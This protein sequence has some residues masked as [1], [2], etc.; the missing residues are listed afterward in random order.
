MPCCHSF[1]DL[2]FSPGYCQAGGQGSLLFKNPTYSHSFSTRIPCRSSEFENENQEG[3]GLQ[4]FL[5]SS[6]QHKPLLRPG[7]T[8]ARQLFVEIGGGGEAGRKKT[9]LKISILSDFVYLRYK[10][11]SQ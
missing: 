10:L 11:L 1:P 4:L 7:N 3:V 5:L 8:R 9:Q 6:R 2:A